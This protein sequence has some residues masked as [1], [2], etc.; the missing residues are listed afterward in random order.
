MKLTCVLVVLLL[1]L[2]YGDLITNNYIRGAARK[3]TPWRRNLKTRD[4]CDS[5]VGGHCI[6]NGCWC[7]QE[8]PHGNCCDTDGCTAAWWCPGTKW[9]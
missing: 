1:L 5:L 6:H 3:V 4:V 8:A 9:D 7:D 2:P